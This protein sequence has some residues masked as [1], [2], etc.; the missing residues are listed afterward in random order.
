M[1]A[2][3]YVVLT[4]V[5]APISFGEAQVRISEALTILP[6]FTP[7]AVPGLFVGCLLGNALSPGVILPDII[8]GSLASLAAAFLTYKLRNK[9]PLLAPLPPIL[10]NTIVIPLILRYAYGINAPFPILMLGLAIGQ[11]LSCG[12]LGLILHTMLSKYKA[13]IFKNEVK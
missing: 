1:I 3:I 2:A 9:S 12:V 8:F 13:L 11:F 10:V 7:A 4:V 6:V 5:F